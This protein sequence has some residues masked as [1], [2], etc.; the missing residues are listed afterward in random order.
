MKEAWRPQRLKSPLKRGNDLD[1]ELLVL[2]VNSNTQGRNAKGAVKVVAKYNIGIVVA[3]EFWV[4]RVSL[5]VEKRIRDIV[6]AS[7]YM[8]CEVEPERVVGDLNRF[9]IDAYEAD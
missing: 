6:G 1:L 3:Q 8:K 5:E 7:N 2:E 9:V 4:Y